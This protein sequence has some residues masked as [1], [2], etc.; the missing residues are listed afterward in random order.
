ME[1]HTDGIV[2]QEAKPPTELLDFNLNKT[3]EAFQECIKTLTHSF[4]TYLLFLSLTAILLWGKG[5][6]EKIS[7]P[8]LSLTID[9]RYASVII[10]ILTVIAWY[11]FSITILYYY[12]MGDKVANAYVQRFGVNKLGWFMHHPSPYIMYQRLVPALILTKKWTTFPSA[13]LLTIVFTAFWLGSFFILPTIFVWQLTGQFGLSYW[14]KV[15]ICIGSV[16]AL[17]PTVIIRSVL[18]TDENLNK[19]LYTMELRTPKQ[20]HF[21]IDDDAREKC[22]KHHGY[23]C[24]ICEFSFDEVYGEAGEKLI[25]VH[26]VRPW[27]EIGEKEKLNP[28]KDLRP[29]CPNCC[30]VKNNGA[31][32]LTEE[33]IRKRLKK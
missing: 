1:G 29:Y 25:H 22:L 13:I 9:K 18:L 32:Q 21:D 23:A 15:F 8:I 6:D 33:A 3:F 27:S 16:C 19:L 20:M 26:L 10:L 11:W 30:A 2:N 14:A 24:S 31:L 7:L 17:A 28:V 4:I 12:L 5:V